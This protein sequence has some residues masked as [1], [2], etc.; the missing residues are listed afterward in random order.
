[1]QQPH[2]YEPACLLLPRNFGAVQVRLDL[3]DV[4]RRTWKEQSGLNF[5]CCLPRSMADI[6]N[7]SLHCLGR[8]KAVKNVIGKLTLRDRLTEIIPSAKDH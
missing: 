7:F 3:P 5:L 1:M 2:R 4:G 8:M 6:I